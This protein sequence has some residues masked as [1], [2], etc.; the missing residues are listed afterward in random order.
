MSLPLGA[1]VN[2]MLVYITHQSQHLLPVTTD[3]HC[4]FVSDHLIVSSSQ[5]YIRTYIT[6]QSLLLQ[7]IFDHYCLVPADQLQPLLLVYDHYCLVFAVMNYV[8]CKYAY[9]KVG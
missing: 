7:T 5:L 4:C 8:H 9:T 6:T 3:N 2:E 1:G